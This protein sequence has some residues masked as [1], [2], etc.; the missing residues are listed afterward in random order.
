MK[1]APVEEIKEEEPEDESAFDWDP[2]EFDEAF[3][4]QVKEG[5]K[6]S[7]FKPGNTKEEERSVPVLKACL[8]VEETS[9]MLGHNKRKLPEELVGQVGLKSEPPQMKG[10]PEKI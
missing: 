8:S 3:D 4:M 9:W 5:A 7:S 10:N 6:I 1:E 2:K